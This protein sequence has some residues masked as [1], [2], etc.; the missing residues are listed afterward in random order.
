[1]DGF[2][3]VKST[4]EVLDILG[5]FPCVEGET[6][7][8]ENALHRVVSQ[9]IV[10]PEDLPSF[11]R[12][13]MDGYAVRARDTFGA[14]E[15]LPALLE[16]VGEVA[17]GACPQIEVG[18]GQAVKISTGGML[19][20]GADSVVMV[21]YCHPLDSTTIEVTRSVSPL[22]NVIQAGD[23]IRKG[24]TVI[25]KGHRLR[26]QDLGLLAGVG[27]NEI[28]A[29]VMPRVAIISTGDEVVD[30]RSKPGPGQVRDI[31]RFTLSAFCK[32][33]GAA[34]RYFG[35]S[36]DEFEDM[37]S[38]VEAGL[39]WG[40]TVWISGGSSVGTRDLTLRV[41]ESFQD[42]ELLVHGVSVSPGKPTIIGR[43][44]KKALI[45]LPGHVSSA[46]VVAQVFM[47]KLLLTLSGAV[48]NPWERPA[49]IEAR[50]TRNVESA[51]GR[52]DYIRVRLFKGPDGGFMAEPLFGKSGLISPLV[53]AHGLVCISRNL[54]GIYEGDKVMVHLLT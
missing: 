3:N 25:K 34:P 15:S 4:E 44:S 54:E 50:I 14:T 13:S 47:Q 31:N 53:E 35:L 8:I 45:G 24:Q 40:H 16:V 39:E 5:Q 51:P 17:M 43:A 9:D 36:R 33:M 20:K 42:F 21:E 18:P 49:A 38:K 32:K 37:R 6:L 26:A 10:S 23:D 52:D 12:S 11:S 30:P 19:P 46:L 22:E 28:P 29:Y 27:I 48:S 41:L 1:M 7:A 2:F